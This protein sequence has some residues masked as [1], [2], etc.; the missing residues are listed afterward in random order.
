M[1]QENLAAKEDEDKKADM[2]LCDLAS[3]KTDHAIIAKNKQHYC[4]SSL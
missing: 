2:D 3:N 4:K 1:I